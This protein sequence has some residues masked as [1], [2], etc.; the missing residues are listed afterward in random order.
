MPPDSVIPDD[1]IP[2]NY[3]ILVVDDESGWLNLMKLILGKKGYQVETALNPPPALEL[4]EKQEF[5]LLIL[6]DMMEG[7]D[8]LEVLK[9]L[10]AD[11]RWDIMPI[12]MCGGLAEKEF[13]AVTAA[14]GVDAHLAKPPLTGQLFETVHDLLIHS[15]KPRAQSLKRI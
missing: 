1:F 10:R 8:G 14:A 3:R 2:A 13:F 6:D 5:D 12:L 11:S 15:R 9:R 7:M 4:L